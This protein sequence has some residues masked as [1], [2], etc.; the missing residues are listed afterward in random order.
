MDYKKYNDYELIYM[1]QENDEESKSILYQKYA[2]IIH[3]L[4]NEYYH[5][6]SHLGYEKDDFIQ[7][8]TIAFY[9]ALY[10]YDERRDSLFYSFVVLCIRRSLMSFCRIIMNRYQKDVVDYSISIDDCP[11]ADSKSD[12]RSIIDYKEIEEI[13]KKTIYSLPIHTSSILELRLNGFSYREI[14]RLLEIPTSSVVFR[15][16]KAIRTLKNE[17]KEYSK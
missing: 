1:V 13:L 17:L 15:E 8:A 14:S 6:Y 7:E 10:H 4:A 5:R 11:M 9:R 2:P 12:L 3:N 16:K